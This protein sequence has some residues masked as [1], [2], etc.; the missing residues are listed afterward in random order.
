MPPSS[1]R[2]MP[3]AALSIRKNTPCTISS[4]VARRRAG[5]RAL[6]PSTAAPAPAAIR[7]C[8]RGEFSTRPGSPQL[9]PCR[10]R[11]WVHPH[12]GL[13]AVQRQRKLAPDEG[14][15]GEAREG[16]DPRRKSALLRARRR[17]VS[18]YARGSVAVASLMRL[19]VGRLQPSAPGIPQVR[20]AAGRSAETIGSQP[21]HGTEILKH[22]LLLAVTGRIIGSCRPDPDVQVASFGVSNPTLTWRA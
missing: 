19:A 18:G 12:D 1:S 8:H 14:E 13:A 20:I 10:G 16:R 21:L 6:N 2:S 3:S 15:A 22:R 4:I 17:S 11:R 5:V 9:T 7:V